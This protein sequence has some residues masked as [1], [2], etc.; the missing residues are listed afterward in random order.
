MLLILILFKFGGCLI[1]LGCSWHLFVLLRG[2]QR[3]LF[4]GWELLNGL[5]QVFDELD[6][7]LALAL[8]ASQT[9]LG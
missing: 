1:D 5:W 2:N 7:L 6:T 3:R 4:L 8:A 9:R